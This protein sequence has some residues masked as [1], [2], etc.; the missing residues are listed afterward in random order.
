MS[1]VPVQSDEIDAWNSIVARDMGCAAAQKQTDDV[2]WSWCLKETALWRAKNI[3]F[4][5][6]TAEYYNLNASNPRIFLFIIEEGAVSIAEKPLIDSTP[7]TDDLNIRAARYQKFFREAA[8]RFCSELRTMIA[9]DLSDGE[10]SSDTVPIFSF[11]KTIGAPAL[12]IPDVDLLAFDFYYTDK[13]L[14]DCLPYQEKACSAIFVG[15]TTGGGTV[16]ESSIENLTLPRLRSAV[17]FKN[18]PEVIFRLPGL[19]QCDSDATENR[20]RA[21]G[22]GGERIPWRDQFAHKFIISIDGNGA[23]CSR[24]VIALRSHSTL[25]KY[26]SPHVLHYFS[27]LIPWLHYVPIS[28]DDDVQLVIDIERRSPGTFEFIAEAGRRFADTYLTR[29]RTMQYT[30]WLFQAY[31]ASFAPSP[32]EGE[33]IRRTPTIRPPAAAGPNGIFEVMAHVQN[34]GD[35][36]YAPDSWIGE[37]GNQTWIEGFAVEPGPDIAPSDIEYQAV[38][39]NGTL[40]EVANGGEFCGS[41]DKSAP[42]LGFRLLVRPPM[43]E[44]REWS[45]LGQFTDGSVVGPV[46]QG[47]ICR[48]TTGAPLEAFRLVCA[49]AGAT[50]HEESLAERTPTIAATLMG[51]ANAMRPATNA[52]GE[53]ATLD[54]P[55]P[56]MS[57]VHLMRFVK[58]PSP[59][60]AL[61]GLPY[62][63]FMRILATRLGVRS[64]LEIGTEAGQSLAQMDCDALCIDPTFRFAGNPVGGRRRTLLFQ[65]QSDEFFAEYEVGQIFPKGVDLAFLDGMHQFEFLLRDFMNTERA[66]HDH[67]IILLHDCLPSNLRMAERTMRIDETED[68]ATRGGW[69]GDVWRMLPILRKYRP[70]LRVLVLDCPPTGLVAVTK[71][72][73]R[74]QRL[75]AAYY[76]ILDEFGNLE[77]EALGVETVWSMYPML[78]TRALSTG[79]ALTSVLSI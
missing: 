52:G 78:D 42:I 66:C 3:D 11:Q 76:D 64:Y 49:G 75:H 67:S 44:P 72:D 37:Y 79:D 39:S 57:E 31:S 40:S 70:D 17:F 62:L 53:D 56:N 12:L 46:P 10:V 28:S 4:K 71:L 26:D 54:F 23:T 68:P 58:P 21:M 73:P 1:D 63:E 50:R 27:A 18:N 51:G 77:L 29:Y 48:S 2:I 69:T 47:D 24:V 34:R 33:P 36:W 25:L 61:P 15:S 74:S 6:A 13:S 5:Y 59:V 16:T 30:A 14:K 20:L 55:F 60:G 32:D 38:L 8:R 7:L 45:Y 41:R 9:V 35:V 22:F 43:S 19:V 65:M